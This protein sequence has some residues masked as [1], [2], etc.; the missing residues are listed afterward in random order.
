M[1]QLMAK[2]DKLRLSD[3]DDGNEKAEKTYF[4]K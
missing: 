2:N 1:L 3:K 4:K